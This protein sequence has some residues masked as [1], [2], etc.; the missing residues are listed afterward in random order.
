MTK[1][2]NPTFHH[3]EDL[4]FDAEKHQYSK[5]I[6]VIPGVNEIL[7][8]SGIAKDYSKVDPFYRDRGIAGHLAIR[9]YLQG[10]LDLQSL[11]PILAPHFEAFLSFWQKHDKEQILSLEKPY[12]NTY[13][14]FA[15]TP[16]L[17]TEE[18]IYD[19]K[20]TNSH[21]KVADLQG[22]GYKTLVYE[23]SLGS[24]KLP[25][26]VVELRDDGTY[27]DYNYGTQSGVWG[28]VMDLYKW[29]V[30]RRDFS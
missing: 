2:T 27:K 26:I 30:T 24:R 19:W 8:K 17:V 28:S 29:R 6:K 18:A 13:A 9:Y 3:S 12:C 23:N 25:F 21:D 4:V 10:Q 5:G 1:T 11:D 22:Q 16:D 7:Q 15:G 20:L 14:T